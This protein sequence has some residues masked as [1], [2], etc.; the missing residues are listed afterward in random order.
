MGGLAQLVILLVVWCQ[1][2]SRDGAAA[3]EEPRAAIPG[4]RRGL[5]QTSGP[6]GGHEY[7]YPTEGRQHGQ[8]CPGGGQRCE[9]GRPQ[10]EQDLGRPA[11]QGAVLDV[12]RPE[13]AASFC[14]GAQEASSDGGEAGTGPD[15]GQGAAAFDEGSLGPGGHG[16]GQSPKLEPA[17]EAEWLQLMTR[18]Q[19]QTTDV[20]EVDV[21]TLGQ[22]IAELLQPPAAPDGCP[23]FGM[24]PA[25]PTGETGHNL[26]LQEAFNRL[27]PGLGDALAAANAKTDSAEKH[28]GARTATSH[29]QVNEIPSA[30]PLRTYNSTSPRA[31]VDPYQATAPQVP[32]PHGRRCLQQRRCPQEGNPRH[33]QH[34]RGSMSGRPSREPAFRQTKLWRASL[35]KRAAMLWPHSELEAWCPRA[36]QTPAG[37][38][39]QAVNLADGDTDDEELRQVASPGLGRLE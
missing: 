13:D 28:G 23:T 30:G 8:A 3:L 9:K 35:P 31:R 6:R 29:G 2:C 36:H 21:D 25:A 11:R 10:S 1:K 4:L 37:T 20:M 19:S 7:V 34:P 5:G 39:E 24:L 16:H 38:A 17:A 32:G 12:L 14:C 18:A 15:G 27:A 33:R 22:Q 26:N